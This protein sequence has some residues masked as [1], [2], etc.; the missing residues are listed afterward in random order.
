MDLSGLH[1][2]DPVVIDSVR[3]TLFTARDHVVSA[4]H[5]LV[6]AW[7]PDGGDVGADPQPDFGQHHYAHGGAVDDGRGQVDLAEAP[8]EKPADKPPTVPPEKR[9]TEGSLERK[10]VPGAGGP[11]SSVDFSI[12]GIVSRADPVAKVVIAILSVASVWSWAIIFEKIIALRSVNGRSDKFEDRFWS[13][14]SV[15]SLFDEVGRR[16]NSPMA[17]LF[18]AAMREWRQSTTPDHTGQQ[19]I[20]GGVK[21]RIERVMHV[22]LGREM[23]RLERNVGFLATVGATAPFIGLFGTVWGIMNSFQH[24]AIQKNTNLATVAPGISEALFATALGLL[25]AIPAVIAYNRFSGELDRYAHRLEGF[26]GEFTAI[27]SRQLEGGV[28]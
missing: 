13:G 20:L 14:G 21:E 4:A 26:T 19:T 5:S 8:A 12:W 28:R 23:S 18:A 7:I 25:A 16:P 15:D 3:D 27:V 6:A 22:T 10:D 11:S 24:I 17:A 2:L 1:L 9:V